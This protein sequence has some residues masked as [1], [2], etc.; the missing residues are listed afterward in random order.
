MGEFFKGCRRK[1]GVMTLVMACAFVGLWF[2]S[3]C[4]FDHVYISVGDGK[5]DFLDSC[6]GK[7]HWGRM[8]EVK[9]DEMPLYPGLTR[10]P[11]DCTG[12]P[13]IPSV[14]DGLR[15]HW[16]LGGFGVHDWVNKPVRAI[17][18][19]HWSVILTLT[20]LSSY[21]LLVKPRVAKP[22]K[23]LEPVPADRA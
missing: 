7:L 5:C 6:E 15:W 20:L 23:A 9:P 17:E 10:I 18:I 19:P 11:I 13:V 4:V 2:R 3:Q 16:K 22:K 8:R 21:L 14:D 12:G 1:A